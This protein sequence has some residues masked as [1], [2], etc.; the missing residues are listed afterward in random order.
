MVLVGQVGRELVGL[1]NAARRSRRRAVR[2]GRRAVPAPGGAVP[3]STVI[4]V[5]VGLVGDVV[6][7]DPAAV[8]D[9][10]EAGRV[11]VVSTVAPGRRRPGAERQRRHRRGGTRGGARRRASSWSSPTS[12]G[13]TRDWPDA[14]I[15]AVHRDGGRARGDAPRPA[16]RDGPEDGGLPAR[17]ARRGTRGDGHRRPGA[18]T[19][20][21][22]R[23]S[24]P[25][26][27]AP[28]SCPTGPRP[29]P[30]R[31][32]RRDDGHPRPLRDRPGDLVAPLRGRGDEHVRSAAAGAGAGR[33]LR[34]SG[35]PT[36]RGTSTCSPASP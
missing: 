21:C 1:V 14:V 36:A 27:S 24:P 4:E 26:A 32:S 15:P 29:H 13:C 23:S 22:S 10:I 7:V 2:R 28:W 9:L 8:L 19:A 11:P 6:E 34:T 12:R 5:D 18:R 30:P 31:R 16:D 3:W 20:S 25:R 35:T 17:G 33:G